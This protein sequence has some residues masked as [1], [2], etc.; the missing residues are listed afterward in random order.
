MGRFST[1]NDNCP[2]L[3]SSPMMKL[4]CFEEFTSEK[5]V[6]VADGIPRNNPSLLMAQKSDPKTGYARAPRFQPLG[7]SGRPQ[8]RY[9]TSE[10]V[11]RKVP[12]MARTIRHSSG[13]LLMRGA[14][15]LRAPAK[16]NTDSST[17][18]CSIARK[19]RPPPSRVLVPARKQRPGAAGTGH[20]GRLIESVPFSATA[21]RRF[22]SR[23]L[24]LLGATKLVSDKV[25]S[26]VVRRLGCGGD[27]YWWW[28]AKDC[29]PHRFTGHP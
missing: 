12:R 26:I 10:S 2:P 22:D 15:S 28:P 11:R 4:F 20:A 29:C 8:R 18:R 25:A 17:Q 7:S 24:I 23:P 13:F 14:S 3:T 27:V 19:A 1:M 6:G 16:V 5:S 21:K 9:C